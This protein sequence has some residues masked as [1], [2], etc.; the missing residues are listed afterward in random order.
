MDC[1]G[2]LAF[3]SVSGY[4]LEMDYVIAGDEESCLVPIEELI[5]TGED[6]LYFSGME[7]LKSYRSEELVPIYASI[8]V[9][10]QCA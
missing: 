9:A 3:V 7:Y 5:I 6:R 2:A 8:S 10:P 4:T 1:N